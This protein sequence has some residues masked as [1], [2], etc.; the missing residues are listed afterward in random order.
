MPTV[1]D[2]FGVTSLMTETF[3][4]PLP[5][6]VYTSSFTPVGFSTATRNCSHCHSYAKVADGPGLQQSNIPLLLK[7]Y[8]VM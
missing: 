4:D 8:I 7:M 6:V 3:S 5:P 1:L 2:I